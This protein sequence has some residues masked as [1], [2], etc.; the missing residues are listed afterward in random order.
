MPFSDTDYDGETL[1]WLT[2]AYDGACSDLN[3]PK[4]DTARRRMVA[5]RIMV[6]AKEGE[7]DV[8][9]LRQLAVEAVGRD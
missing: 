2:A 4:D 3:I 1:A 6:A 5:L 8:A 9:K 7:R